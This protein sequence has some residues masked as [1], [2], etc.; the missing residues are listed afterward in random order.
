M[1]GVAL[2]TGGSTG[3]GAEICRQMLDAGYEVVSLARRK[4]QQAHA[5]LH[6]IDVDLMDR[7]G[8]GLAN[9][10]SQQ[11]SQAWQNPSPAPVRVPASTTAVAPANVDAVS[12]RSAKTVR[13]RFKCRS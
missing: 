2:V 6:A 1:T 9:Q 12:T 7:S 3:I 5:R 11:Q 8:G 13:S 10:S 4:P